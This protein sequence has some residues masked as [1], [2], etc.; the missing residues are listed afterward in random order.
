MNIVTIKELENTEREVKGVGFT[1]LR[2]LLK[3][4]NMGFGLNKT[5]IPK[6]GPYHWHYTNHLEACYCIQG[7]GVITN[8]ET[9]QQFIIEPD[10]TYVLDDYDD[11]TFEALEDTILI[12]VF[13]PPLTGKEVHRA[14]GS[15]AL[16]DGN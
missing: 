16:P 7:R 9:K 11:H 10:T 1:S 6:G 14:D 12:S 4:D 3:Q 2:V 15:Y 8:L 13:N 5:I